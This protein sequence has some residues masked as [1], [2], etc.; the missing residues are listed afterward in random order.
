M[1]WGVAVCRVSWPASI[2]VLAL[3]MAQ[4][5]DTVPVDRQR[6]WIHL[7]RQIMASPRW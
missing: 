1:V 2:F 5:Q 4:I 3:G 7:V 6:R